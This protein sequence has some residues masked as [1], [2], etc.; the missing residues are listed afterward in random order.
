LAWVIFAESLTSLQIMG[1]VIVLSGI[2]LARRSSSI[3][4]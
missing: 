3:K 2:Y 1:A 4:M